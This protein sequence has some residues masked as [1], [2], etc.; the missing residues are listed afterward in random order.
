LTEFYTRQ[1]PDEEILEYGE[2]KNI[3]VNT[4]ENF[5]QTKPFIGK[6][7]DQNTFVAIRDFT[8]QYFEKH[9]RL[10]KK[11]IKEKRIVDGHGDLHLEHIHI[12]P[13]KVQIYDCIEFNERFRYGD[14]AADLAFLAMDLDFNDRWQEARYFVDQMAD[15]LEDPD[16]AKI[17]DFY[18][19][20]RAYVK[21][22]VKSLQSSEEEVPPKEREQAAETADRYFNLSLRY[23]LLGSKP[24]ALAFMGRVGTGKSTLA[25]HFE[26]SLGIKR[27]STDRIRKSLAKLPLDERTPASARDELYSAKMSAQTYQ[28]LMD[29]GADQL[30]KGKSVILDGTFSSA[31]SRKRLKKILAPYDAPLLFI[32]TQATDNVIKERLEARDQQSGVVSDARLEDFEKLSER[33][34]SPGETESS[35]L[36]QISTTQPLEKTVEKLYRKLVDRNVELV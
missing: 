21:G 10:F 34:Q 3:K 8:N 28:T 7:I 16:L 5:S 11:R 18:K 27:F 9:D 20:Y 24:V 36:I 4:D 14:L 17:I 26:K 6:T 12:T 32:E 29:K 23:A 1:Q 22:K 31:S 2:I 35:N 19:C 33:Y 15:K 30:K 25:R 13:E